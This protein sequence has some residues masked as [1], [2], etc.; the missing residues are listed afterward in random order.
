M[1]YWVVR[2]LSGEK[3]KRASRGLR[4]QA[5]ALS[6]KYPETDMRQSV[7]YA[8]IIDYNFTVKEYTVAREFANKYKRFGEKVKIQK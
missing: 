4:T 3:A 8:G 1:L 6:A 7:L 2:R 5:M